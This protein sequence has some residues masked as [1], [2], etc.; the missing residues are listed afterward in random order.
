MDADVKLRNE[1]C[2]LT[3]PRLWLHQSG[4]ALQ[5][6]RGTKCSG[7]H[8]GEGTVVWIL[9]GV[10]KRCKKVWILIPLFLSIPFPAS[11]TVATCKLNTHTT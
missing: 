10:V 11:M 6:A 1:T 3:V 9:C 5:A 2:L 4:G 7:C 8:G